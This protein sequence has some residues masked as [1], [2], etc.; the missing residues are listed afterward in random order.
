[1]VGNRIKSEINNLGL[2]KLKNNS[3]YKYKQK[4][5]NAF[6][7]KIKN[8]SEINIQKMVNNMILNNDRKYGKNCIFLCV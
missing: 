5:R 8:I 7:Q 2:E 6:E 4:L 1:M 3:F